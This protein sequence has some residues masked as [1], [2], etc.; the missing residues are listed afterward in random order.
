MT[1]RKP[2]LPVVPKRHRLVSR[3]GIPCDVTTHSYIANI[4]KVFFLEKIFIYFYE[5]YFELNTGFA[6][7]CTKKWFMHTQKCKFFFG[8]HRFCLFTCS[9]CLVFLG[10]KYDVQSSFCR[11]RIESFVVENP[12]FAL[13]IVDV[14]LPPFSFLRKLKLSFHRTSRVTKVIKIRIK[15]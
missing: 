15:V 12:Q 7:T 14:A 6:V 10:S 11:S 9:F 5:S 8:T 3:A 1:H 2:G 4:A 13:L